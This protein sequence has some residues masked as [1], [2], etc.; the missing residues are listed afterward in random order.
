MTNDMMQM[1]TNMSKTAYETSRQWA[2]INTR[3][4]NQLTQQQ[5]A[6]LEGSLERGF[7]AARKAMQAKDYKELVGIQTE[8]AEEM[9]GATMEQTRKT[10]EVFSATR[11]AW[12]TLM[13]KSVETAASEIDKAK[14]KA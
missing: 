4:L 8:V 6:L 13:E 14:A 11:D 10:L 9:A 5:M 12:S 1:M 7:G 2:D 3:T